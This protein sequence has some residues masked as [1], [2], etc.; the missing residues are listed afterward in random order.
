MNISHRQLKMFT[1]LAKHL[2][3]THAAKILHVTQPAI[4]M[5][6]KQLE[7]EIGLSLFEHMGKRMFLTP[8][9]EETLRYAESIL[10]ELGELQYAISELKG[11]KRG[12]LKLM[13]ANSLSGLTAKLMA[14]FLKVYPEINISL[15]VG[16][17][18][19][20]IKALS[21]NRIDL[22]IMGKTPVEIP[23]ESHVIL[24]TDILILA[25]PNH[26]LAK[27][28]NISLDRLGQEKFIY[29]EIGSATRVAMDLSLEAHH[30]EKSH[31]EIRI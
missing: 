1:T 3:F 11:I 17:R 27:E 9:G 12:H 21:E 23:V 5:Q 16:N 13:V 29:G 15:E 22:A 26:P 7:D 28:K 10:A 20:Q 6:I 30:L 4:S 18:Q 24:T 8:A 19:Q 31:I 25:A 2:N 14:K